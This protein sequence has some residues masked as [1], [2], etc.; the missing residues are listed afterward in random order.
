MFGWEYPPA[1]LGGLGVACQGLVRGLLQ[2]GA[3]VTLVLPQGEAEMDPGMSVISPTEQHVQTV[4]VKSMLQ[5]YD[6]FANY[7]NRL[8]NDAIPR[9]GIALYGRDLGEA[10]HTFT[11]LSVELTKDVKADVIH[12]HD[13]MTFGA[14]ARAARYHRIPFVAHVHATELDRTHF[15]PNEWIYWREREGLERSD[16]IITV[17]NYT[18]QILVREYGIP[19][20]KIDVVHNGTHD[21]PQFAPI[22]ALRE[23][24]PM[25][26]F[27]GRL[28]VQKG[29]FHFLEAARIVHHHRPDAQFVVAGEGYL[30]PELVDRACNMGL[31]SS[32]LFAG[33]V[34]GAEA[35][36][37]YK[38]ASCF[39]MPSTSEP[40]GL[41]ALEAIAQGAPVILSKQSGVA[42]VIPHAFHVD[43]WDIDKLADCIATVLREEPLAVQLR[44]EATHTLTRLRWENQAAK[45]LSIYDK[46]R[47]KF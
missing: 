26:L 39:V 28:T 14:G 30:L 13:W 27:L 32:V 21:T 31:Q 4:R 10:V 20:D 15:R 33:K 17:S 34:N 36:E 6:S 2:H 42:E 22:T 12:S 44:S 46:V 41:V 11:E 37:L 16:H 40:F 3:K 45:V 47:M 23:K 5:P 35:R 38:H 7:A 29:P 24:H 19:G 8:R 18:K 25:V 9:S 1:H 43:F